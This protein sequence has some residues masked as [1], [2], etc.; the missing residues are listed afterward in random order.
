MS[1]TTS[2]RSEFA[3]V[4]TKAAD[5]FDHRDLLARLDRNLEAGNSAYLI[6]SD[7][8]CVMLAARRG[9]VHPA[10]NTLD[11][12]FCAMSGSLHNTRDLPFAECGPLSDPSSTA[13]NLFRSGGAAALERLEGQFAYALWDAR[14]RTLFCGR[15]HFGRNPLFFHQ[16]P[17][18]TFVAT[19]PRLLARFAGIPLR[20]DRVQLT[21]SGLM[22]ERGG[23][24]HGTTFHGIQG[25][26]AACIAQVKPNEFTVRQY[27][28][29]GSV[30]GVG[31]RRGTR[32]IEDYWDECRDLMFA[33]VEKCLPKTGPVITL[34]SGGLDSSAITA[35]AMQVLK[36]QNRELV[37]L[38]AIP[39]FAHP[40]QRS[41]RE[42]MEQFAGFQNLRQIFVT[43]PERGPFDDLEKMAAGVQC[44]LWSSRHFMYQA[45]AQAANAQ[46]A[47]A[48]LD[49]IGGEIGPTNPA[50]AAF[51]Q[52]AM[53]GRWV[54]L[55]REL[56]AMKK[57]SEGSSMASLFRSRLAR[58]LLKPWA[59][60]APDL[61]KRILHPS[62]Y[63]D[64]ARA[65]PK[66]QRD[67]L[68][69][70]SQSH[71]TRRHVA[72]SQ[73][74]SR[75]SFTDGLFGA[76]FMYPF[77]DKSLAEFAIS[78]PV[79]A[80]VKDGYA[81]HMVRRSLDGV[82]PKAIQWRTSKAPFSTD[83]VSRY[84]RQRSAAQDYVSDLRNDDPA[85]HIVDIQRLR[86]I[87]TRDM[88]HD[89]AAAGY[90]DGSHVVPGALSTLAFLREFDEL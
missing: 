76:Q 39:E 47:S 28:S 87:L 34:L 63:S 23:M 32:A 7:P 82:L 48:I 30:R 42:F 9:A 37:S 83:Y 62:F 84:N 81:R 33:A 29:P 27:W 31:L 65:Q 61:M 68:Y 45:F 22:K 24:T 10:K 86:Q 40:D 69:R 77:L 8:H 57:V 75:N 16:A 54:H 52:W 50:S 66:R 19:S 25:L 85:A 80:M 5:H 12:A 51:P 15:D 17:D 36:R 2:V 26:S 55:T 70:F 18:A 88:P 3:A 59:N 4:V 74:P 58:P 90:F 79:D 71:A 13:L 43:A 38:S 78:A 73:N 53:Q 20:L 41:E 49:G 11:Q 1:F 64:Y 56:V 60:Q 89:P 14:S 35:M 44:P 46:G 21:Q 67:I 72:H 6:I